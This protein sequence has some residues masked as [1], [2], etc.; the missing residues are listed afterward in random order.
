MSAVRT[1]RPS[2]KVQYERLVRRV[3]GDTDALWPRRPLRAATVSEARD[4]IDEVLDDDDAAW[5]ERLAA[6]LARALSAEAAYLSG[7]R[8]RTRNLPKVAP[9]TPEERRE[10]I[11]ADA[12]LKRAGETSKGKRNDLLAKQFKRPPDTIRKITPKE[13]HGRPR[14]AREKP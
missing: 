8:N 3:G 5:R 10:I 9:I 6:L 13:A 11:D 12:E 4:L 7:L 1:R 2:P 14:K